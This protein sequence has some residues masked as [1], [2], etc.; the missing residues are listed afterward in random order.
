MNPNDIPDNLRADLRRYIAEMSH[1][2]RIGEEMDAM[3]DDLMAKGNTCDPFSTANI[4]EAMAEMNEVHA[5]QLA[6]TA[7]HAGNFLLGHELRRF[8]TEYWRERA[9]TIAE[10]YVARNG[11]PA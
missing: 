5:Q 10:A 1:A 3:I 6:I 9:R 2:D 11:V 4:A 8:V 7:R